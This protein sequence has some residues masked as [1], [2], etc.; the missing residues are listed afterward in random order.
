MS[1]S[2]LNRL[3]SLNFDLGETAD[4]LR[5]SVE[6]F[7]ADE[8]ALFCI[9]AHMS[10]LP[11]NHQVLGHG[12]RFLHAASTAPTYRL[13]DL[14]TR[15][16]LVRAAQG[17]GAIAG[18]VWALPAAAIGP[19]LASIPPP[20]AFGRVTLANGESV[21]GFLAEGEGV[22]GTPEITA[23]GGWRAHLAAR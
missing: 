15:P 16:G 7:A 6:T 8:I 1:A 22:A 2:L 19:F 18:E 10:G 13:F 20:L 14:G 23:R 5:G 12:G 17:G 11:L 21:L 4:M 9:G 3:P